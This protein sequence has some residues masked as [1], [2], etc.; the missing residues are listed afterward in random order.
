MIWA[1]VSWYLAGPIIT[2]YGWIPASEYVDILGNQV[3]PMVEMLFP[4]SDAVFQD[5]ISPMRP[6]RSVQSL[7]AEYEDSLNI[8]PGQHNHQT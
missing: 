8:F 4:N 7:F 5:N 3:H 1:A 2:P 6:T